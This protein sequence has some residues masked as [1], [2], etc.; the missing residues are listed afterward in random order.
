MISSLCKHSIP[1]I[2]SLK[3]TPRPQLHEAQINSRF[4]LRYFKI[5]IQIQINLFTQPKKLL[6]KAGMDSPQSAQTCAGRNSP[7]A[8]RVAAINLISRNPH[9]Q[10]QIK[11]NLTHPIPP[12][13]PHTTR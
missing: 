7:K 1:S 9:A 11:H 5:Q 6:T 4:N 12:N 3:I 10:P 13:S 8:M 2:L